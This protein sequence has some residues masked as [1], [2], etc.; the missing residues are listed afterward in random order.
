MP[1]LCADPVG[2][3]LGRLRQSTSIARFD[4]I[5]QRRPLTVANGRVSAGRGH[6]ASRQ[7]FYPDLG[8]T[9]SSQ[10][11]QDRARV[12]V[13]MRCPCQEQWRVTRKHVGHGASDEVGEFILSHTLKRKTP[14]GCKTRRASQ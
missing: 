8:K 13:S 4:L 10:I 3:G 6:A 11:R 5:A 12:K 7:R 14:P 1:E 2:G 9:R